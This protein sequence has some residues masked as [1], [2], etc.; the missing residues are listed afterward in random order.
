[1]KHIKS[2]ANA[3]ILLMFFQCPLMAET[4]LLEDDFDHYPSGDM[5]WKGRWLDGMSGSGSAWSGPGQQAFWTSEGAPLEPGDASS[6]SPRRIVDAPGN[7]PG[8]AFRYSELLDNDVKGTIGT[9]GG[10]PLYHY[11]SI[12][13]RWDPFSD[14]EQI[15]E[16]S[17]DF[18]AEK[19]NAPA[20][21]GG[22]GVMA[23]RSE[24]YDDAE[25]K[26][27]WTLITHVSLADNEGSPVIVFEVAEGPDGALSGGQP[28]KIT[29]DIELNKWYQLRIQGDNKSHTLTF[30]L[31]N[32][33]LGSGHYVSKRASVESISIGDVNAGSKTF[34]E[35]GSIVFLD[36]VRLKTLA[37][38]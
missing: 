8:Q 9:P 29:N 19:I 6:T 22:F 10:F 4:V 30:F 11:P 2:A 36:N 35:P 5:P 33:E 27:G 1:M 13:A 15:W 16:A 21:E 38:P 14:Q 23:I 28:T 18:Y 24:P 26:K 31:D 7:R 20:K 3:L 17:I 25:G 37:R 12:A 32:V 34:V